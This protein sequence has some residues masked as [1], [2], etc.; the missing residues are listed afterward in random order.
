MIDNLEV[1][2]QARMKPIAEIGRSLGIPEDALHPYGRHIAKVDRRFLKTLA[3]RPDG[4]LVLVTATTPT[5]AGEGKTTTTVG[6]A[7]ALV[8]R[9]RRAMVCLREPS[10]GPCFGVKGGAAGGGYSQVVPMEQINLHFTGDIHA[11]GAAHNLLAAVLD[12]HLQQ[13]NALGIEPRTLRWR[14]VL[15]MNDR[16]LRHVVLGLGGKADGVPRES[17]F[18]ITVSSEVMAILCLATTL[19][20]L[21]QRLGRIVVGQRRDGAPVTAADLKA[22]GAMAALLKDA[23]NPNLVQT[24][25]HVPAF[26]HG[27]PFANIAHGTSSVVAT[28]AALKLAD[29][30][31]VEAGFASD[32]GAEK[33]FDIVS[34][35]AGLDPAAVV[36]VTTVRSLKF[37]G[38]AAREALG[39]EDKAA[40]VAGLPNLEAHLDNLAAFGLPVVVS[41]NRFGTDTDT[42]LALVAQA[43]ADRGVP[44]VVSD[45]F[46]RGGEGGLDLADRVVDA[47]SGEPRHF[48]PR[49]PMDAPL[50]AK[51]ETL[52]RTVYGADGVDF[53]EGVG[54][55]I[56]ALEA[57]GHG[58]LPVCMAKTPLSLS[59]DPARKGRPTGFRIAVREVRLSAGA[60]FVVAICGQIMTMP[61]LPKVP[62]AERI[63]I[64][65]DGEITGLF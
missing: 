18:D 27:G 61:G 45:V 39:V 22:H 52:A 31:V 62:A 28:R 26:V 63:D 20:D 25:E 51:I 3:D 41:I 50:T 49:Y 12:N 64:D 1:A 29:I 7:Q 32:L 30:V 4:R 60:G 65:D 54:R 56:A 57:A 17:G 43:A 16:A 53:V 5:P 23:M 14:R 48:V 10:L 38:G 55:E 40:L 47:L 36:L 33:F 42:E 59:D 46:A 24:L 44:T 6:L 9:G 35:Q 34:R 37:Q 19:D 2:R 11:V 13:G 58:T 15:D 21:K 8:R